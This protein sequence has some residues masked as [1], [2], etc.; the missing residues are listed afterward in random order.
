MEEV[1]IHAI[2]ADDD[3]YC[4]NEVISCR[5]DSKGR[6]EYQVNW[7]EG[8]IMKISWENAKNL[9]DFCERY[10]VKGYDLV[11]EFDDA[12][13][14]TK[15]RRRCRSAKNENARESLLIQPIVQFNHNDAEDILREGADFLGYFFMKNL[16]DEYDDEMEE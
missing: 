16:F 10:N 5:L 11:K 12:M 9:E 8:E 1:R 14:C 13:I 6:K 2:D 7:Q 15:I 4:I 3:D